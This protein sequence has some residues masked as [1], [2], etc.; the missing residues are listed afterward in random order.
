MIYLELTGTGG[1]VRIVFLALAFLGIASAG[2]WHSQT[3]RDAP[4][5]ILLF[6]GGLVP[7]VAGG[8]LFPSI[9]LMAAG[10]AC[11]FVACL[12]AI[13]CLLISPA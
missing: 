4:S 2:I 10:V 12:A 6:L 8:P 7:F 1:L 13:G 11:L 3:G 5:I 9:T